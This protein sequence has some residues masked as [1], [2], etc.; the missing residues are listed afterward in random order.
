MN[1]QDIAAHADRATFL[2]GI[3]GTKWLMERRFGYGGVCRLPLRPLE[4][5]T[6][7]VLKSHPHITAIE[8]MEK[9][10]ERENNVASATRKTAIAGP[11]LVP[12]GNGDEVL[13]SETASSV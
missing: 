1:L 3:P 10:L 7:E 4:D 13:S 9:S 8:E 11:V 6:G 12:G 5:A 2:A